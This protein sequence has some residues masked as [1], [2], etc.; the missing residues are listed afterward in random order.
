MT[1]GQWSDKNT[2]EQTTGS[3][4]SF[5]IPNVAAPFVILVLGDDVFAL[6]NSELLASSTK[7]Q[8]QPFG[9]VEGEFRVGDKP[10]ANR[11][12]E[13]FGNRL[14]DAVTLRVPFLFSQTVN[15]D[16]NG[17][18]VFDRIIPM[19]F[20]RIGLHDPRRS[21][22]GVWTRGEAVNVRPGET[23]RVVL[24]GKGRAI[25]GRLAR[26]DGV[27]F[28]VTTHV[29]LIGD[30]PLPPASRIFPGKVPASPED[31][32]QWL[33]AYRRSP[34]VR[35][36]IRGR[37]G[38]G[39]GVR[40]DGSFR[41]D[42]A[43][44]GHYRLVARLEDSPP[45]QPDAD[46]FACIAREVFVPPGRGGP[47]DLGTLTFRPHVS[48][49]AGGPAPPLDVTA[50]DGKRI[51]LADLRGKF[52]LLD[53]GRT[54]NVAV[55][56]EVAQMLGVFEA[57]GKDDRLV[58]VSL[59]CESDTPT[60]RRFVASKQEPWPQAI[61]GPLPNPL[62]DSFGVEPRDDTASAFIL[63]GPDGRIVA[64]PEIGNGPQHDNVNK[65][66]AKALG[67]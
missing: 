11:P 4:G 29:A 2:G 22:E 64:R 12:I 25:V 31:W 47:I 54:Y 49:R 48:L 43:P 18:F 67:K 63:I 40:P 33:D 55:H 62:A 26:P 24:G 36:H 45:N 17:H 1:D 19:D 34:E 66:V 46:P 14:T 65:A 39:V 56:H 37:V 20:F 6:T 38:I 58:I 28:G 59:I 30:S 44:E 50:V 16:P 10:L 15:T 32:R 61:I 3:D 35:A 27:A 5:A 52:V 7:V 57:F 41:I 53:F 60:A 8:A 9:R 13:L 42:N 21:P 51:S 23:T